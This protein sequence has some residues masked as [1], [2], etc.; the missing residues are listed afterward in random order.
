MTTAEYLED[1]FGLHGQVAVVIG[2]AGELG[3][4]LC[5]GILRAGAHVVIADLLEEAC[6]RRLEQLREF[7]D[8]VSY[9]L[10]DVT[11]RESL[12]NLLEFAKKIKGRVEILVN[13]AGINAGSSFLEAS[14]EMWDKIMAVNLKG[15]FEACQVFIA[16]MLEAGG[17]SILNIGSVT[18]TLPLSRVFAYAASKRRWSTSP[19]ISLMSSEIRVLGSMQFAR[20]SSLQNRIADFSTRNGSAISLTARPCIAL[21]SR[22][23]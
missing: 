15:V 22:M 23:S 10:V 1:L 8:K 4:A 11:K 9:C 20:A 7:S 6:R 3:G 5:E 13:C 17:G 19:R 16:H 2:G 18:S 12:E 21:E 14:P